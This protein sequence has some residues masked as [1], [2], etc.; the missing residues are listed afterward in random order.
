MKKCPGHSFGRVPVKLSQIGFSIL[1]GFSAFLLSTGIA[2]FANLLADT[3]GLSDI[4][5][6]LPRFEGWR[7]PAAIFIIG[8]V[9]AITEEQL[10]RG[11]LLNAWRPLG[12]AKAVWLT[13]ILFALLHG[14][15]VVIPS[16]L[17]LGYMLGALSFDTGSVYPAITVHMTNNIVSLFLSSFAAKVAPDAAAPAISAGEILISSA[18]YT[19]MGLVFT[20]LNY[21]RLMF[22]FH[23]TRQEQ[24]PLPKPDDHEPADKSR[25]LTLPVVISLVLLIALIVLNIFAMSEA[26][27]LELP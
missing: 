10:F 13:A 2:G 24:T 12:R 1:L 16:V 23:M 25:G 14:N 26:V 17:V 5:V 7:G 20:Y 21:K 9:P 15:P 18:L 19:G 22:S 6:P 27:N 4:S 11:V 3:A 8:I